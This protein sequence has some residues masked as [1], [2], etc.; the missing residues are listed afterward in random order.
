[1]CTKTLLMNCVA[2]STLF[3]LS[4]KQR[5]V[6]T[7]VSVESQQLSLFIHIF[8]M[9]LTLYSS[10]PLQVEWMSDRCSINM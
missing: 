5:A 6:N 7:E 3:S 9:P 2:Q 4:V 8:K 10:Q 1:M